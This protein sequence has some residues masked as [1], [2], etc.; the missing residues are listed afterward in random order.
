MGGQPTLYLKR[1]RGQRVDRGGEGKKEG[2]GRRRGRRNFGWD[3]KQKTKNFILCVY[4]CTHTSGCVHA[5][6]CL[7]VCVCM[8]ELYMPMG[9]CGDQRT[10][11]ESQL[12]PS[13]VFVLGIELRLSALVEKIFTCW[14][15][16]PTPLI[17]L[18]GFLFTDNRN[19]G[20]WSALE[21]W[22]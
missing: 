10:V 4:V 8:C 13:T 17:F 18:K 20:L 19:K 14:A 6:S 22:F 11:Y 16:L 7:H 5:S 15:I 2:D 21:C 3:V 9:T 12:S 1:N